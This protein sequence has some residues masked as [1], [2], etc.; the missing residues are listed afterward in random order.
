[1]EWRVDLDSTT[2]TLP[3]LSRYK[4]EPTAGQKR[5][6]ASSATSE[7]KG[8]NLFTTSNNRKT[9]PG[10]AAKALRINALYPEFHLSEVQETLAKHNSSA[11]H[12]LSDLG[13]RSLDKK[14]SHDSLSSEQKA[15]Y[16]KFCAKFDEFRPESVLATL[17]SREWDEIE[18]TAHLS[19]CRK[20]RNNSHAPVPVK[21][22]SAPE[23]PTTR[24]DFASPNPDP[25]RHEA[26]QED[27]GEGLMPKP[28]KFRRGLSA[29]ESSGSSSPSASAVSGTHPT[30]ASSNRM[31]RPHPGATS[32]RTSTPASPLPEAKIKSE[33]KEEKRP[34]PVVVPDESED[35]DDVIEAVSSND[36]GDSDADDGGARKT[37][38]AIEWFN[39]ASESALCETIGCSAAQA[40]K[41][42]SL[43][44]FE[45]EDDVDNKLGDRANK[46]VTPR[47]FHACVEVMA[48]YQQV[49]KILHRVE[50]VGRRLLRDIQRWAL[51]T[52]HNE[53][54]GKRVAPSQARKEGYIAE[55]P[56]G[57]SEQFKL[58]PYQLTGV[59][60]LSLL[61]NH[62][63]SA[64]L[65]DEMGLGKT[66][67]VISFLLALKAR[68][69]PGPHLVVAP[70]S[71]LENWRR[72][73]DIAANPS[74]EG[75]L[76]VAVYWG[77]Q[78]E[79]D[80]LRDQIE[81]QQDGG[82]LDVVLTT[83]DMASAGGSMGKYDARFFR[84]RNFNVCIFDEGHMLKNRRSERYQKL[85]RIPAHRRLLLTGTPL[86]NHLGELLSLLNFILPN[87]F[88]DTDSE[89]LESIFKAKPSTTS[90]SNSNLLST[91][92]VE[93]AK[94]LMKPFV[95]RRRKEKVL[96]HELA[97]KTER[98]VRCEMTSSQAQIYADV[99]AG[100][101]QAVQQ[102]EGENKGAKAQAA[103]AAKSG[104]VLMDLRK[105]A[106]H[107]LLFRRRYDHK[108][109]TALAKDYVKNPD[110][111][112]EPLQHVE[113]D[114][115]INSDASLSQVAQSYSVRLASV[116]EL[117]TDSF[118]YSTPKSMLFLPMRGSTAARSKPSRISWTKRCREAK[119]CCFLASSPLCLISSLRPCTPWE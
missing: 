86:Q 2:M 19:N 109:I 39:N 41:I 34:A 95:L 52:P 110:F 93:R 60:W 47:L 61:Y 74:R 31:D 9:A 71:V 32:L 8:Q 72:E 64:I 89:L 111:A 27:D 80:L 28:R 114:F 67:Q 118:H 37:T 35:E 105:A 96:A 7:S 29:G 117:S 97:G 1:M 17:A 3:D 11:A 15:L 77:S 108:K 107:P 79:R 84:R 81:D 66:V 119:G 10:G 90:S 51:D 42:V 50:G 82:E 58:K 69:E 94:A 13:K 16:K 14:V 87:Y 70:S 113:E 18:T 54:G 78:K 83:Y 45:D 53:G 40:S 104:H 116:F 43:R 75:G 106:N 102:G 26:K 33:A 73:L 63:L 59:N 38:N 44:P 46:G 103:S 20:V 25:V 21:K 24:Q 49:D 23:E 115:A 22:T 4:A 56:E 65:A 88:S 62:Q 99:L 112:D 55:Q 48:G 36:D 76:H 5:P 6:S 57:L 98:V 92:R 85:M 91:E 68:G 100:A 12:A 30:R 101:Q